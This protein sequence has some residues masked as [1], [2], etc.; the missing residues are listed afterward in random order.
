MA[1]C[2]GFKTKALV[3]DKAGIK[4]LVKT[5]KSY[6]LPAQTIVYWVNSLRTNL[7]SKALDIM[8]NSQGTERERRI[9]VI[10]SRTY[11]IGSKWQEFPDLKLHENTIFGCGHSIKELARSRD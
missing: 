11:I 6:C 9:M 4:P 10:K 3:E 7:R 1:G 8:D 2:G 5:E